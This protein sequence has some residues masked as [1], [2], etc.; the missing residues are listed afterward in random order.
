MQPQCK[1]SCNLQHAGQRHPHTAGLEGH[2]AVFAVYFKRISFVAA[3][4]GNLL[5]CIARWLALRQQSVLTT[6]VTGSQ[7]VS[8]HTLRAR[9]WLWAGSAEP[10]PVPALPTLRSCLA[11]VLPAR[12]GEGIQ[13][14]AAQ[15]EKEQHGSLQGHW[16][17]QCLPSGGRQL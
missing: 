9:L 15:A 13:E 16:R 3:K 4:E 5:S 2:D 11:A 14:Y 1:V 7:V 17:D 8:I 6:A 12:P 10:G